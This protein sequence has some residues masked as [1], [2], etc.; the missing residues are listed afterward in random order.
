LRTSGANIGAAFPAFRPRA[1]WWGGD[2]QTLRNT[3]ARGLGLDDFAMP[4]AA[5]ELPAGDGSGD[6]LIALLNKGRGS[7]RRPLAV[8]VHGLTGC[9]ESGYM[10][11]T[12]RHLTG[13]GHPVLRL[14]MRGAGPSAPTCRLRYHA[15]RG[16][17]IAAA[18]GALDPVL[19][20]D[21]VVL[22]GYSLGGSI[23]LN[24]LAHHVRDFPVR[25]ATT[26]SAPIDLAECSKRIL[27]FRN[28][29][30]Q[31]YL[32]DR[33][34]CD[35]ADAALGEEE[36]VALAEVRTI[37]EF[38][39]RVVAPANGFGTAVNY[40]A[41]CSATRVLPGLAIPTLM[42]HAADDPWIP[43]AD[44]RAVDWDGNP[45]LTPLLAPGGG[46]VGFHRQGGAPNW[47]DLCMGA[48]FGAHAG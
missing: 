3:L 40:Y 31:R 24:F 22:A 41:E 43:A 12:T 48:F 14:N 23:L 39:D 30:Y 2:L 47:H 10:V 25:A 33:M 38:D 15:G 26:V 6:R 36:G 44:Y 21:G 34:K 45:R 1:P 27:E 29:F 37:W 5:L 46:H 13:L 20:G 18:L 32:V 7:E 9:H 17:D 11:Q 19:L 16:E 28:I 42:I 4:G 8:L 35:W